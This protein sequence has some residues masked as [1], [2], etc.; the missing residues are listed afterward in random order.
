MAYPQ[1]PERSSCC[2]RL[3]D[4]LVALFGVF[5]CVLHLRDSAALHSLSSG[6]FLVFRM[7]HHPKRLQS[8]ETTVRQLM[9]WVLM[10]TSIS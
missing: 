10:G 5:V 3:S 4:R 2:S 7:L 6:A 9:S 1:R 8:R